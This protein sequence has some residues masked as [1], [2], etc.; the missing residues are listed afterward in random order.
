MNIAGIK[1]LTYTVNTAILLMVIG[2]MG[3][4]VFCRATFLVYFSI[5]TL[6]VYII[7]YVLI[8]REL[9]YPY[10]V[11]VYCWITIYMGICTVCL[12]Y[13]YG[14]HLYG[15]SM[16]PITFYSDYLGYKINS[17]KVNPF[18]FSGFI[19]LCYLVCTMSPF[20]WGPI[21]QAD[22]NIARAFWILNSLL[23][24]GFLIFYT[25]IMIKTIIG[26]EETLKNIALIDNLTGLHNRHYIMKYLEEAEDLKKDAY[27]SMIDID[28][29]KKINDV[30]GHNAGDYV[31]KTLAGIM[32][33][34]CKDFSVSRWGGE[35]FLILMT[36]ESGKALSDEF[37]KE[38]MESLRKTVESSKFVYED[39]EI[40][41]TVTIGVAERGQWQTVERWVDA[42]DDKLYQ[43]KNSGKNK[44]VM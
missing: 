33:E 27:V 11:M 34:N 37:I 20:I 29:F 19:V 8:S 1:K 16:I 26:S 14:F 31:L 35:E 43:G 24:F 4:F 28:S 41:V 36:S 12:G 30:Y 5:P 38:R 25:W 44:V 9:L 17:R 40:K 22:K 15:M 18:L 3:F 39:K 6:L 21:Y 23:V 42:A 13:D 2:L 7:G 32:E 10:V